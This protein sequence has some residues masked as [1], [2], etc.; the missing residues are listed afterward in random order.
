[1]AFSTITFY[2]RR[3]WTY[4][5]FISFICFKSILTSFHRDLSLSTG[6]RVNG[7]H[8]CIFFTILISC[9]LFMCPNQLYLWSLT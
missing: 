4:V 8:L 5:H 7:F 6:L 1:L 2:L 9:I 3:Y